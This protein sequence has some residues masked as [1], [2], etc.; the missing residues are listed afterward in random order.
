MPVSF[1]RKHLANRFKATAKNFNDAEENYTVSKKVSRMLDKI[2]K[3]VRQRSTVDNYRNAIKK[4]ADE[5][6]IKKEKELAYVVEQELA[7]AK[8]NEHMIEE[9]ATEEPTVADIVGEQSAT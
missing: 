8:A 5:L 9:P 1:D 4:A 2:D 3:L 7:L 6:I